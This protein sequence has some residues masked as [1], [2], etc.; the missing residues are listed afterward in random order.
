[1][2]IFKR[3][4]RQFIVSIQFFL[5]FLFILFEEIIWERVAEPIYEKIQS[6]KILQ[7]LKGLVKKVDKYTLLVIFLVFLLGV[8][9]AGILAGILLI[10]GKLLLSITLYIFKVSIASFTFWLFKVSKSKLLSFK[11]FAFGYNLTLRGIEWIKSTDIYHSSMAIMH[12]L[13]IQLKTIKNRFFSKKG[14]SFIAN[15][16]LFYR[17]IKKIL[18]R[19]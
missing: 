15:M 9:G 16:K 18:N 5:V 1:V 7:R 8:E 14:S 11:W 19:K 13:K 6:L 2:T 12:R 3:I 4:L 17:Y 10:K